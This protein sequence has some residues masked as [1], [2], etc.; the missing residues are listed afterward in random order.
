[1]GHVYVIDDAFEI[2][3][4]IVWSLRSVGH[5]VFAFSTPGA[6]LKEVD[7]RQPGVAVVDIMLPGMT[8]LALCE[9][10]L[11]RKVPC[12]A[13][14]ISGHADVATAVDAMRLGAVDFLEKPFGMQKL[15]TSVNRA[16]ELAALRFNDYTKRLDAVRRL[17]QLSPR[18]R[19]VA[20]AVADGEATK[21][22]ARRLEISARTV[23]VHRSRIMQ[24]L[25]VQSPFQLAS[26][27]LMAHASGY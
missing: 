27:L 18:E 14:M 9:E 5:E 24:K 16:L 2:S 8:G 21:E 23:D 3:E 17:E 25:G 6:F 1:M 26:M 7:P 22:I 20:D 11:R 4:P 19:E 12:A 10:M 15:A 13:V